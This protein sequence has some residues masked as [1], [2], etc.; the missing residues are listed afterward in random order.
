M[1]YQDFRR[2]GAIICNHVSTRQHPILMATRDT[3]LMPEDSGWQF[4][5]G[6]LGHESGDIGI[7]MLEEVTQLDPSLLPILDADPKSSFRRA[8]IDDSWRTVAYTNE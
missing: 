3:P 5:C 8:S 2:C 6:T 4:Q 1:S 7:W